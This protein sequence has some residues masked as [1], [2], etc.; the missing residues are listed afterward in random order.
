MPHL[1][2]QTSLLPLFTCASPFFA[3]QKPFRPTPG[4]EQGEDVWFPL[5]QKH[6]AKA[7]ALADR[8]KVLTDFDEIKAEAA[9]IQGTTDV[10]F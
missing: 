6:L 2:R 4:E 1:S 3:T 7:A 9:Y 10:R 8:A 5:A